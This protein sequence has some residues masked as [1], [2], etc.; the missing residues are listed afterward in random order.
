MKD[1]I[2]LIGAQGA[3][4]T[5]I[6]RLLK[7]VLGSPHIDFDWIRD[8]HLDKEWGNC[9]DREQE[10]SLENLIHILK[11]YKKHHFHNI[12]TS[13]F[14]EK[15][16]EKLIEVFKEDK[17]IIITLYITDDIELKNRVLNKNRD[18]GFRDYESSIKF[19]KKLKDEVKYPNEYKIDNTYHK[20]EE[21]VEKIVQ[22]L[23]E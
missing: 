12:I 6:A 13:G 4:K 14:T 23:S 1:Y 8:F 2:F 17:F 22:L 21:I 10:M 5:T 18:S 3:G 15:D 20:P 9:S 11:N 16:I 7:E 19:N